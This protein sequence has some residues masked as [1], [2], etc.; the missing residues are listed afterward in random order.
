M[1]KRWWTLV[2]IYVVV[3]AASHLVRCQGPREGRARPGAVSQEVQ[4]WDRDTPT[5]HRVQLSYQDLQPASVASA[6]I[7][8]L[9]HGSPV[10][11][12]TLEPLAKELQDGHRLILPDLPGFGGSTLRIADYSARSYAHYALELLDHLQVESAHVFAYSMGGAVA[13]QMADLAPRR[14][15]SLML[16][17]AIGVQELELLGDYTLNHAVHGLQ[18]A[19]LTTLQEGLPH[20]GWMDRFPLNRYYARNFFDLDQRPLRTILTEL[21]QPTLII[22]GQKDFLVP[23][24]AGAEHHRLVPQSDFMSLSEGDHLTVIRQPQVVAPLVADFVKSAEAG[25]GVTRAMADE[26]R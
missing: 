1:A 24:N 18:L 14:V 17:A 2:G 25:R 22:H 13:L 12:V 15:E 11:A 23:H 7:V 9:L 8:L 4:E 10:A 20:F 19:A 21:P 16:F 26:S 5:G 6:P 3:L